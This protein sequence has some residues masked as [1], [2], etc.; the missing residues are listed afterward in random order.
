M[1]KYLTAFAVMGFFAASAHA[2]D[3]YTTDPEFSVPIFE[4]SHLGF[5]TQHGRFNKTSGKTMIDFAAK[6]GSVNFTIYT[7]SLDMGLGAWTKHLSDEGL[8]NVKKFPT[9]TF[10]SDKLIF[11]GNKVVAA[12][13]QFTM[14][15]VTRPL[16][17]EVNDFQ[18]GNNPENKRAMC[19][20]NVTA[21]IKR[22]NFG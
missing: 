4:V 13:G 19:A 11:E 22:S 18:C 15:G 21:T 2:A 8:F 7:E 20:A 9:M 10:K 17:I 14:I 3:S 16:K 5:T 1:K 12:E 6:K